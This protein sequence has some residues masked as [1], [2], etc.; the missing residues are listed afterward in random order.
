MQCTALRHVNAEVMFHSP[1]SPSSGSLW[2][3]YGRMIRRN[4]ARRFDESIAEISQNRE[5]P[6]PAKTFAFYPRLV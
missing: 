3:E 4:G 1:L 6:F 2:K 5:G